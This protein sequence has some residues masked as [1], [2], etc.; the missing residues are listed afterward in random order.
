[1]YHIHLIR[2]LNKL[3]A[4]YTVY[5][6]NDIPHI[7]D[8]E[9][10]KLFI[11]PDLYE[12]TAEKEEVLKKYVLNSG[13]H[14]MWGDCSAFSD[15]RTW[16]ESRM[17]KLCKVTMQSKVNEPL[18]MGEWTSYYQGKCDEITTDMLKATAANAGVHLYT[19]KAIPVFA[20][21]DLL[22]IHCAENGKLTVKMPEKIS[23][24]E[25]FEGKLHFEN[26]DVI[27]LDINAP[28]TLLFKLTR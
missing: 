7:K 16:D 15:G 28:E 13:K 8:L 23:L 19:D 17:E 24:T 10:I 3:G 14:V 11:F 27:E 1:M 5:S 2:Q 21:D 20:S 25:L 12:V 18:P 4:P 26:T 22:M 9:R 6:F